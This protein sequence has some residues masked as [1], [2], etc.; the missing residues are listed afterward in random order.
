MWRVILFTVLGLLTFGGWSLVMFIAGARTHE[1]TVKKDGM[2]GLGGAQ[3]LKD[4]AQILD[5]LV[6]P[7]IITLTE[8]TDLISTDTSNRIKGWL[9]TYN[10]WREK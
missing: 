3:L 8:T 2:A 7:A 4:G 5:E 10:K 6:N 9:K 1:S